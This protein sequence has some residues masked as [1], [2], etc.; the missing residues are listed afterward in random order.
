MYSFDRTF[1]STIFTYGQTY[2]G[3][4]RILSYD[5]P[6]YLSLNLHD[7]HKLNAENLCSIYNNKFIGAAVL[8][9]ASVL[10]CFIADI[11]VILLIGAIIVPHIL[12]ELYL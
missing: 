12:T 9:S 11:S 5:R 6:L 7:E 3:F 8:V 4:V 1:W 2:D 10:V